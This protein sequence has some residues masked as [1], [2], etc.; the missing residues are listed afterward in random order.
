MGDIKKYAPGSVKTFTCPN[1]GGTIGIRAVG[2]SITAVCQ[3]CGSIIDVANEELS[4]ISKAQKN[5]KADLDLP[6]GARGHLFGADWEVI[7]Y[8]ERG[9]LDDTFSWSEYLLFNPWQG[10]R[11]LVAS[12][13]HWTFVK[14]LR[15]EIEEVN[16]PEYDGKTYK[17]FSRDN[18][19][20][21]YVLGEFYW[22]TKVGEKASVEDY[23]APPYILSRE[24]SGQ[25]VIWS[26]GTYV[27][28]QIIQDAFGIKEKWTPP[29]GIAPNQPSPLGESLKAAVLA[30][31]LAVICLM[32]FQF[33][34][35]G[36]AKNQVLI[37]TTIQA[38]STQK[39]TPQ[40]TDEF[41]VPNRTG[42]LE[43]MVASPVDNDWL[44]VEAELVNQS[45]QENDQTLETV[46]YYHGYDS[47]GA[48]AEGGQVSR[49]ILSAVPGG[50]YRLL[51]TADAGAFARNLPV[52][53]RLRVVR[54]VPDWSNFWT[55]FLLLIICPSV[56]WL[57]HSSY[58]KRRWAESSIALPGSTINI[59]KYE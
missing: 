11:F 30:S 36:Q 40:T 28:P 42:N 49:D 37:D 34:A 33:V 29:V 13:G 22:R 52:Q 17:L 48:W 1:C 39:G 27:R 51:L 20:V 57:Y 7:G 9:D 55:A 24:D 16:S 38:L 12:D 54:D 31:I 56:L 47:D 35:L 25:D 23:V 10:F 53:Y 14:M 21:K 32:V 8:T 58:E 26:Q 18:I 43:I 15:Q 50:K 41:D 5:T 19:K 2:I 4:V 46:E 44:E 3:S 59:R 45:T 6:L